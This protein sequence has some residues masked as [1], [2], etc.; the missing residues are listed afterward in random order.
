MFHIVVRR[1]PQTWDA[2]LGLV[3]RQE[4]PLITSESRPDDVAPRDWCKYVLARR[5]ATGRDVADDVVGA[6]TGD[7]QAAMAMIDEL[8]GGRDLVPKLADA[9]RRLRTQRPD[10]RG[11]WGAF[12]SGGPG[13]AYT[14]FNRTGAPAIDEL[15]AADATLALELYPRY[16]DYC[17][18]A[19]TVSGR[20][21]WMADFF[22]GESGAFPQP[23]LRWLAGR[24][25]ELGS[26]SRLTVLFPTTDVAPVDF[27]GT[28]EPDVFLDRM[29]HVWATRTAFRGLMLADNGGI[30]TYKWDEK[31]TDPTRDARFVESWDHYCRDGATT[32]LR[33]SP[34]C[35]RPPGP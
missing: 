5:H 29:F 32:T 3:Q 27:L 11:R 30:G 10:L 34:G 9:A 2:I 17:V 20:D 14:A 23:R 4:S 31:V 6:L 16:S 1:T 33:G 25:R 8:A 7:D 21:R 19:T 24:R 35:G 15:L 22:Q 13:T 28:A 26:S 12:V 18:S